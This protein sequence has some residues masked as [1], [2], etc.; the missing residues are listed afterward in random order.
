MTKKTDAP[1][2][3]RYPKETRG[4]MLVEAGLACLARGGITAFTVDN[5]CREAQ[6]SRGLIQ[7]HFG[8]KD[9]LLAAVYATMYDR[10]TEVFEAAGEGGLSLA[11]LVDA[12][13]APEV[14]N[15]ASLKTWLALW[16]EIANNAELRR[17]HRM[18]YLDLLD[19][20]ALAVAVEAERH[21]C[22]VDARSVAIQFVA[23]SDGLWLEHGIDTG[24][25]S[26]EDARQALS[27][28]LAGALRPVA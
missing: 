10:F 21:G 9:A 23:L 26:Q 18:R 19:R 12:C 5:I 17:V 4:I 6:V 25:L 28:F 14:F 8:S 22:R 2:Y 1:R 3:R 11:D 27:D 16:G 24:M 15:A 7:H 20:V 13:V